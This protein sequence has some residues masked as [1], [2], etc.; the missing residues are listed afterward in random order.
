LCGNAECNYAAYNEKGE[1]L[2]LYE[3]IMPYTWLY[4]VYG[5]KEESFYVL[6]PPAMLDYLPEEKKKRM[7]GY[8]LRV[9]RRLL[10]LYEEDVLAYCVS[11]DEVINKIALVMCCAFMPYFCGQYD[12]LKLYYSV[13]AGVYKLNRAE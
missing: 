9:I 2:S 5:G 8:A 7:L 11:G 1:A 3:A 4:F 6:V 13:L 10:E 12:P